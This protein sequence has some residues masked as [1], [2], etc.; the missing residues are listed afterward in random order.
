M[1]WETS[2]ELESQR[3]HFLA[4]APLGLFAEEGQEKVIKL[5]P[6]RSVHVFPQ[7]RRN[8]TSQDLFPLE[9][10]AGKG[11]FGLSDKVGSQT[12]PFLDTRQAPDG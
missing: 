4:P 2:A 11:P 8:T 5:L 3:G 1:F 6:L 12:A 9:I 7:K 10:V